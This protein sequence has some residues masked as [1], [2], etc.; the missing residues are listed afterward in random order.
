MKWLLDI[1]LAIVDLHV[2]KHVIARISLFD[3]THSLENDIKELHLLMFVELLLCHLALLKSIL[4]LQN[5]VDHG[6]VLRILTVPQVVEDQGAKAILD[7]AAEDLLVL[8]FFLLSLDV[9]NTYLIAI[10]HEAERA[11][12]LSKEELLQ[13]HTLVETCEAQFLSHLHESVL[14]RDL[15]HHDVSHF[16][17]DA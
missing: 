13:G 9:R 14:E 6:T 4:P 17:F 3:L 7:I 10:T 16:P 2:L 15:R 8:F 5:L 1:H 12:D 11:N